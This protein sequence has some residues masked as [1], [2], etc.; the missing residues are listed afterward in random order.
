MGLGMTTSR[1]TTDLDTVCGAQAPGGAAVPYLPKER[2][3]PDTDATFF[4][5]DHC[6]RFQVGLAK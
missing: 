5:R 1:T 2:D 3:A 6:A 4:H